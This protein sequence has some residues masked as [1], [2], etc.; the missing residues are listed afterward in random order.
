M[1]RRVSRKE[2]C[3]PL[4]LC[5]IIDAYIIEKVKQEPDVFEH[6]KIQRKCI[7][8]VLLEDIL[9]VQQNGLQSDRKRMAQWQKDG[10]SK[11]LQCRP[12]ANKIVGIMATEQKVDVTSCNTDSSV[13]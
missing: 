7:P 5:L 12:Q 11:S 4:I 9:K 6:A 2:K 8:R 10:S 13:S 1:H 3:D